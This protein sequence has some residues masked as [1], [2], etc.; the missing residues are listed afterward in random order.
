MG[1]NC[2]AHDHHEDLAPQLHKKSFRNIL[3]FSMFVNFGMFFIEVGYGYFAKSLSLK[4]DAID[5][6]GDG[7]NYLVSLLVINSVLSLRAK[8]SMAKALTMIIFGVVIL[9]NGGMQYLSG[10]V[11]NSFTM[12]WVGVLALV[13]NVAV[14]VLLFKFREGDS[15]MQSVWLCSR[16]DAISNIAVVFAAGGVYLTSSAW[17][18]LLVAAFMA[19]LSLSSGFQVLKAARLEL[20]TCK[21]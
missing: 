2:C 3:I 14:A 21:N 20:A 5:F 9:I 10:D 12:T 4:A 17:P 16:N 6:F 18:D 13:S 19:I 8:V 1:K 15:N 7:V 11:P